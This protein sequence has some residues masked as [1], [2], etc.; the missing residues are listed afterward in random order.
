M[1]EKTRPLATVRR[2]ATR[3]RHIRRPVQVGPDYLGL[4]KLG[5]SRLDIRDPYHF[6]VSL[7]WPGFIGT[8]LG[9]WL[10]VNLLF[11][12]LYA[13]VPGAV[14]NTRHGSLSD[15]FFFS[16]ETLSTVGYGVMAPA[17][18]YGHI[19]ASIETITG[20]AFTAIMT[21]LLFIRFSRAKPK[22]AYA[23]DAVVTRY[24]GHPTLMIRLANARAAIMTSA[25]ARLFVIISEHTA[26]GDLSR[27]THELRL[28][29][30]HQPFFNLP[31]TLMHVIDK[32]SPLAG[33]DAE[34][35]IALKARLYLTIEAR[36]HVLSAVVYDMKDYPAS[37]IRFGMRFVAAVMLD[38][39]ANVT[40]D[41]SR[42]G[43][44]EPADEET[45]PHIS[46][47]LL[48]G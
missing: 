40:A 10:V 41:L 27:C 25:S 24:D 16:T 39:E 11:A 5:I 35:L 15:L 6:A 14:S 48:K 12:V 36:D 38:E 44:I 30:P 3:I 17:T 34:S 47:Q 46:L 7:S 43:L 13:C 29:Q 19:I 21:G 22:I 8:M 23:D 42:I 18:L 28:I 2:M 1:L 45:R 33:H 20:L 31:W 26:E 4:A 32:Q 37:R 9:S